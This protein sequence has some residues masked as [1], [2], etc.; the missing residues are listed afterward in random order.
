M[1]S[2]ASEL[3]VPF[4]ITLEARHVISPDRVFA[5][6]AACG[7]NPAIPLLVNYKNSSAFDFLDELG[8]VV[9]VSCWTMFSSIFKTYQPNCHSADVL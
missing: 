1:D 5:R 9:Q 2:F 6:V 7:S 8:N 4:P 3:G